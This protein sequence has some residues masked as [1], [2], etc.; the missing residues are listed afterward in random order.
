[1]T[2]EKARKTLRKQKAPSFIYLAN[3][4]RD[5]EKEYYVAYLS[6]MDW[7]RRDTNGEFEIIETKND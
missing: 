2:L 6:A 3:N 7:V 5:G 4:G 1:M